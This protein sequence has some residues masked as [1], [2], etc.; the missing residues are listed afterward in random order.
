MSHF[1]QWWLAWLTLRFP[2]DDLFYYGRIIYQLRYSKM[3]AP[4]KTRRGKILA[5]RETFFIPKEHMCCIR[6]PVSA[7]KSTSLTWETG[8]SVHE[9]INDTTRP[10]PDRRRFWARPRD[11]PLSASGG[12]K[13]YWSRLSL[14]TTTT[15]F[16]SW[17][18]P[19]VQ[20]SS[21]RNTSVPLLWGLKFMNHRQPSF[22]SIWHVTI[23]WP[24]L[25]TVWSVIVRK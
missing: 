12:A 11:R 22:Y 24:F 23:P 1:R 4:I 25:V 17:H 18:F 7:A 21:S 19:M 9:R 16:N 5:I 6:R 10:Y 20:W 3:P 13:V 15:S 8:R 2:S 14:W